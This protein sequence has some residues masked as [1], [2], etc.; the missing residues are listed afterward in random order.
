[1]KNNNNVFSVPTYVGLRG[2]AFLAAVAVVVVVVLPSRQ[3]LAARL[4]RGGE[5]SHAADLLDSSIPKTVDPAV[6]A[7]LHEVKSRLALLEG[8]PTEA[9]RQ[10][11][12]AIG[13]QP[14]SVRYLVCL[15]E[16]Y[17]LFEKPRETMETLRKAAG[18]HRA[19]RSHG[20][21]DPV[22]WARGVVKL[23]PGELPSEETLR[24]RFEEWFTGYRRRLAWYERF[25]QEL[26]GA[27][28]IHRELSDDFPGDFENWRR[29]SLLESC[30]G[31]IENARRALQK[32]VE[33]R[34][35][36]RH[37]QEA[38][39]YRLM[40][41][42][43]PD[44]VI[45]EPQ[46]A[47]VPQ[48]YERK[49]ILRSLLLSGKKA[50]ATDE[51]LRRYPGSGTAASVRLDLCDVLAQEGDRA[52]LRTELNV[53]FLLPDEDIRAQE[54]IGNLQMFVHDYSSAAKTFL[55]LSR[56][57][58]SIAQYRIKATDSLD[59]IGDRRSALALLEETQRVHPGDP[60]LDREIGVRRAEQGNATGALSYLEEARRDTPD[61][62]R[63][64]YAL[65]RVYSQLNRQSDALDLYR[66][67][68][69]ADLSR[70]VASSLSSPST[71]GSAPFAR[72]ARVRRRVLALYKRSEGE[73]PAQNRIQR[74]LGLVLHHLGLVVDYRAVEDSLL[75]DE[76]LDSY[77]GIL[78]WF[79]TDSIENP[80]RFARWL[81][82]QPAL[83]RPLVVFE[84]LGCLR[85]NR[86]GADISPKALE[87]LYKALGIKLGGSW[88][89]MPWLLEIV[90]KDPKMCDFE[91]PLNHELSHFIEVTSLR[92]ENQVHLKIRRKDRPG[93][94]AD[95]V[96]TG[97]GGGFCLS[98]YA[99]HY[100]EEG[101]RIQ[102]RIDPFRFITSALRLEGQ[103]R[104]DTTSRNGTRMC[105]IDIDG[106]GSDVMC[107]WRAPSTCAEVFFDHV[108]SK[109][110]FLFTVSFIGCLLD[111][112]LHPSPTG[113][114]AA[115][116]IFS[117][118]QVEPAHHSYSHPFD[119][120]GDRA[121]LL[122][123]S[124]EKFDLRREI[125]GAKELL[126]RV[127]CPPGKPIRICLWTGAGNPD[128]K[129]LLMSQQAGLRNFNSAIPRFDP[130]HPSVAH[131]SSPYR[132]VEGL[133]QNLNAGPSDYSL[134]A[135]W[136]QP[137]IA[138]RNVLYTFSW[139]EKPRRLI[140]VNLYFHFYLLA[141][142]DGRMA[143]DEVF[144]WMESESLH[145]VFTS[146]YIRA[147]EGFLD[148]VVE[149]VGPDDWSVSNY[150]NCSSAR[151]DQ[152]TATV[153]L[154]RSR[155]VLGF[156]HVNGSLY[157]HLDGSS[158]ARILLGSRPAS[159]PYLVE[160]TVMMRNLRESSG[161][162]QFESEGQG[163]GRF[164]FGGLNPA[165][166]VEVIASRPDDR[167]CEQKLRLRVEPAGRL[168]FS[169][170]MKGGMVV[171]IKRATKP[172]Q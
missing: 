82:R 65:A 151:F 155:G 137:T 87:D 104:L 32:M 7:E 139:S 57:S 50:N 166:S 119:W 78:L 152:T 158:P 112:A 130:S 163:T 13:L 52:G 113:I 168:T 102:W 31:H 145:P 21:P 24:S 18:L 157:V 22:R 134:T 17:E 165:E 79:N 147:T 81:A 30:A 143:L 146:D 153:D 37:I 66:R 93:C 138:F 159:R 141:N 19:W 99:I 46:K 44:E 54:R 33:L 76:G 3:E 89:D 85:D 38:L 67:L 133:I 10:I 129:A 34:P 88:T 148:A 35:G 156:N 107:R 64:L 63:V 150:G 15:A 56:Q 160:S 91:R 48:D 60:W 59:A 103:P 25:Y 12:I 68:L 70:E 167:V 77:C 45:G 9:L 122:V 109:R 4:V 106:D 164:V 40:W 28:R 98:T 23:G 96:V 135:S 117:H 149:R 110:P 100:D 42:N 53:P 72:S 161:V 144:Q 142:L 132:N 75:G 136:T 11:Q 131:L 114:A 26:D 71:V 126:E 125:V 74:C 111:P 43:R 101:D 90:H 20:R 8:N 27:I 2:V 36:I 58:P 73:N 128:R 123:P 16:L 80:D 14:E 124:Y 121:G 6:R 5:L 95:A 55:G 29:L 140:P 115:R 97:P 39:A 49:K 51:Y 61:D 92:P 105:L 154:D 41:E 120:L 172:G 118:Q 108:L 171:S 116:R 127:A 169:L 83:G 170:P 69:G 1:M 47:D 162:L 84:N 62:R 94:V 86:S